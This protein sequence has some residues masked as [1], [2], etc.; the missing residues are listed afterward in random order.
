[1]RG[2][3]FGS[4]RGER[5]DGCKDPWGADTCA[6]PGLRRFVAVAVVTGSIPGPTTWSA[7]VDMFPLPLFATFP[8]R[9]LVLPHSSTTHLRYRS[10]SGPVTDSSSRGM[11]IRDGQSSISAICVLRKSSSHSRIA[12]AEAAPPNALP[13]SRWNLRWGRWCHTGEEG[14]SGGARRSGQSSRSV[15]LR[16]V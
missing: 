14:A 10:S 2:W 8:R 6:A 15:L 13:K 3:V 7:A 12:P 5:A 16:Q 1:M 11:T 4:G 9:K